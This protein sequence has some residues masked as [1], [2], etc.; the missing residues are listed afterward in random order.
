MQRFC[1]NSLS[2][3]IS[4][5]DPSLASIATPTLSCLPQLLIRHLAHKDALSY[6]TQARHHLLRVDVVRIQATKLLGLRRGLALLRLLL[7]DQQ[8]RRGQLEDQPTHRER[9]PRLL[10]LRAYHHQEGTDQPKPLGRNEPKRERENDTQFRPDEQNAM[11]NEH[12][13]LHVVMR[14]EQI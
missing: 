3:S 10:I 12:A 13:G 8:L 11:C 1:G 9:L 7:W 14:F 4:H 6:Q 2:C 5:S